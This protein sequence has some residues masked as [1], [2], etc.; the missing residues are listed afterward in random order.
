MRRKISSDA[1]GMLACLSLF[2]MLQTAAEAASALPSAVA[3]T[4]AADIEVRGVGASFPALVYQDLIFAYQ[5]VKPNVKL[6]YLGSGSGSG[7]CRIQ[8]RSRASRPHRACDL[9]KE[10]LLVRLGTLICKM[11]HPTNSVITLLWC[12][13]F[14]RCVTQQQTRTV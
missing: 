12:R 2:L 8:V 1:T 3:E 14:R 5:F 4:A 13:S 10:P 6:S 7:K 11:Y 9:C